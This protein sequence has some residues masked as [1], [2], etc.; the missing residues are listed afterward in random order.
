MQDAEDE[1]TILADVLNDDDRGRHHTVSG[2]FIPPGHTVTSGRDGDQA[3]VASS[4]SRTFLADPTSGRD[5]DLADA[6]SRGSRAFLVDQTSG[7]DGDL[8]D[9]ASRGSRTCLADQTSGRDGDLADMVSRGRRTFLANQTSGRDGDLAYA[10]SR[11]GGNFLVDQTSGLEADLA[12]AGTRGRMTNLADKTPWR[13]AGHVYAASRGALAD[14]TSDGSGEPETGFTRSISS[15]RN[16]DIVFERLVNTLNGGF[17]LPKPDLFTFSGKVTDYCKFIKNFETNIETKVSDSSLRLS[18]LI[19]YF[20]GEAKCCIED[21]VLLDPDVG[22]KRAR[23][24]LQSRYGRPHLIAR[25]YI[26]TIVHGPMI[27]ANDIDGLLKL[28][29]EMQKCEIALSQLGFV[30]DVDNTENLKQIVRRLPMHM[31]TKWVETAH[32]IS[33]SG[34]EPRFADLSK[35]VDER[36]RLASSMSVWIC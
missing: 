36:S 4:G 21:C 18:N 23:E 2:D 16:I 7:R 3:D 22:Y 30:S 24:I 25:G 8:A 14:K 17:N 26:D 6:A 29:L 5:G 19:Q 9:A 12:G 34:R 31:R 35:F 32:I 20:V 15:T 27:M 13:D 11:V 10:A 28:S 33:E 1:E